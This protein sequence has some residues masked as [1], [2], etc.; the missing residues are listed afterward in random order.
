MTAQGHYKSNTKYTK[1]TETKTQN[2]F[3]SSGPIVKLALI[4][5]L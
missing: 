5:Q 2:T 4:L 3:T 1:L